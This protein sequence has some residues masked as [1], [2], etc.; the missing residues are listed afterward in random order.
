MTVPSP[1][2]NAAENARLKLALFY[3]CDRDFSRIVNRHSW[4][5]RWEE[6]WKKVTRLAQA[7][8]HRAKRLERI[9]TL[10]SVLNEQQ[11]REYCAYW[12]VRAA[13]NLDMVARAREKKRRATGLEGVDVDHDDL[14]VGCRNDQPRA[15]ADGYDSEQE[16][17]PEQNVPWKPRYPMRVQDGPFLPIAAQDEQTSHC[18]YSK[19]A[20][21][22]TMGTYVTGLLH[23]F[24]D[25]TLSAAQPFTK[26]YSSA[27]PSG[28][29]VAAGLGRQAEY[30]KKT[31]NNDAAST[32][33]EFDP[34][35]A[36]L[37][38]RA[39]T[40]APAKTTTEVRKGANIRAT[41]WNL[42]LSSKINTVPE[43]LDIAAVVTRQVEQ[44]LANGAEVK[45][46]HLLFHGAGGSGK[47]HI[48]KHFVRPLLETYG[49]V[50]RT[51]AY[52]NAQAN[53][54]GG[55]TIHSSIAA[56]GKQSLSIT[57]VLPTAIGDT[58]DR[59]LNKLWENCQCIILEECSMISPDMAAALS[60]CI[61]HARQHSGRV[62]CARSDFR[63]HDGA[64]GRMPLCIW[65]GDFL[66]LR[67]TAKKSLV[68]GLCLDGK[69]AR[70]GAV[71]SLDDKA[72]WD[73]FNCL[74]DVCLLRQ[75]K[76]FRE[77]DPLETILKWM[78][79]PSIVSDD[80]ARDLYAMLEARA[81]QAH[82]NTAFWRD[83]LF[84]ASMWES[85]TRWQHSV[86][87]ARAKAANE[88]LVYI[89]AVDKGPVGTDRATYLRAQKIANSKKTGQMMGMLPIFNGSKVALTRKISGEVG[90][91]QGVVGTVVGI[92][93][94]NFEP[95]DL[96]VT[97]GQAILKFLPKGVYV[98]FE[99]L[100]KIGFSTPGCAA[101]VI[102]VTPEHS[103]PF[104]VGKQ[105]TNP[106]PGKG[107]YSFTRHQ[108]PLCPADI[109]TIHGC[110]G[111]TANTGVT[112]DFQKM[113]FDSDDDHW[114]AT[115][116][117][118]SRAVALKHVFAHRLPPYELF[119]RGPPPGIA[120]KLQQLER[121]YEAFTR[122]AAQARA[123]LG[124]PAKD[125]YD[126]TDDA[127]PTDDATPPPR[128]DAN[129]SAD[130]HA[131]LRVDA[132]PPQRDDARDLLGETNSSAHAAASAKRA[133]PKSAHQSARKKAAL[134]PPPRTTDES[135][136]SGAAFI[137]GALFGG[138][139]TGIGIGLG[140]LASSHS[141]KRAP[142]DEKEQCC[143]GRCPGKP[144]K[145]C[146]PK[147]RKPDPDVRKPNPGNQGVRKPDQGVRK[148]DQGVRKSDQEVRKRKNDHYNEE[149]ATILA[150]KF[151]WKDNSCYLNAVFRMLL[152]IPDFRNV[153]HTV[154]R[155]S[156]TYI[157]EERVAVFR[158]KF[159][160]GGQ[161]DATELYT[162]ISTLWEE[163]DVMPTFRDVLSFDVKTHLVCQKCGKKSS[164]TTMPMNQMD[165]GLGDTTNIREHFSLVN[166]VDAFLRPTTP[167]NYRCEAKSC[168]ALDV[169]TQHSTIDNIQQY[170]VFT[171]KRFKRDE[172]AGTFLKIR[173][174]V[175][176]PETLH[177]GGK[178]LALRGIVLHDGDTLHG[179]HYTVLVKYR[180]T[181]GWWSIDARPGQDEEQITWDR[182]LP[183]TAH[184]DAYILLYKNKDFSHT[185]VL[186]L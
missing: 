24:S 174:R 9:P 118:L 165:V 62:S 134:D 85:V 137:A 171:L 79:D 108:I 146:N 61:T 113:P 186:G 135:D 121:K 6:H 176:I 153:F 34:L 50:S 180:G 110:Q 129:S 184:Y 25:V 55:K 124:W 84:I 26:L 179:G 98:H 59:A 74:D 17:N 123:D 154:F 52:S 42:A 168:K 28:S 97:N 40:W 30:F 104:Q 106:S 148:P 164:E 56:K 48:I 125:T 136:N 13:R 29:E 88:T 89:Q 159:S 11:A 142:K 126:P 117:A 35:A 140:T 130:A 72:G 38:V 143:R 181:G 102:L 120:E 132:T 63:T 33:S 163:S 12:T 77:G 116:V 105:D 23:V 1:E 150:F 16:C 27:R 91:V 80:D 169:T 18:V 111:V 46:L 167:E 156:W 47:S 66:Q 68:E 161:E 45:P 160:R 81:Q 86:M 92:H 76:R 32:L 75:G 128:A 7:A 127:P 182:N 5:Q 90:L 115:Y 20:E 133:S 151:L 53:G 96:E 22:G 112:I 177:L 41:A 82:E 78:R 49:L 73:I 100:E 44:I 101:G 58:R 166:S 170:V 37:L 94:H 10:T 99:H 145:R 95:D 69:L 185:N 131:S 149:W 172:D 67:P 14:G 60:L 157:R 119:A 57:R 15:K 3:P 71:G 178:T 109:M 183:D 31:K 173:T 162:A 65:L 4:V 141:R 54:I 139:S 158:N 8:E 152:L 83:G 87:R 103:E 21:R 70:G 147:V 2:K 175:E 114:L 19:G 107:G 155:A 122:K 36:K 144:C 93:N 39:P 138:A 51:V 64:F 43:Q